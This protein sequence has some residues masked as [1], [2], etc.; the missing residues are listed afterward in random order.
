M[1]ECS[2]IR[3]EF[4]QGRPAY[5]ASPCVPA[6][7]TLLTMVPFRASITWVSMY[8]LGRELRLTARWLGNDASLSNVTAVI[9]PNAVVVSVVVGTARSAA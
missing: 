1:E 4:V 6:S 3:C 5:A 8:L 7:Y 9:K 2:I